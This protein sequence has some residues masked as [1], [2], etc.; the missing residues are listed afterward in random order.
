M[1]SFQVLIWSTLSAVLKTETQSSEGSRPA[2]VALEV[3][4]SLVFVGKYRSSCLTN[5]TSIVLGLAVLASYM[6]WRHHSLRRL[7]ADAYRLFRE[8][9]SDSVRS[10]QPEASLGSYNNPV[11]SGDFRDHIDRRESVVEVRRQ[12]CKGVINIYCCR[13]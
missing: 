13:L 7:S 8:A 10:E 4:L 6:A 9:R 11:F 2:T 12:V 1:A 3:I 5:L